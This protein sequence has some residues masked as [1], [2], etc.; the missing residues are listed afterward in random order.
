LDTKPTYVQA[1]DIRWLVAEGFAAVL[2]SLDWQGTRDLKSFPE[3]WLVK[4]NT[5]RTV[6]HLPDPAVPDGPGYFVKRYKFRSFK[7]KLKHLVVPTKAM[8]EWRICGDLRASGIPT[9][10]VLAA[11]EGRKRALLREAFLISQEIPHTVELKKF[12]LGR[13][14]HERE[15]N[16]KEQLVEE[17]ACLTGRLVRLGYYH[18][19]FHAGNILIQPDSPRGYRL[20]VL[21]L[22]SVRKRK[23]RPRHVLR[24]LSMLAN[25]TDLPGVT[26]ADRLRFLVLF[27]RTWKG[28]GRVARGEVLWWA[29]QVESKRKVLHTRHM[30][31]RTRRCLVQSTLF[32]R[33]NYGAYYVHRRRDFPVES[34]CKAAELH[35]QTL[36]GRD[37][38][39]CL[40]KEGDRTAVTLC[41]CDSV[42]PFEVNRPAEPHQL[43]EGVVCVKSFSHRSLGDRLKDVF[44]FR[45]R[46]RQAWIGLSGFAA[47]G[48]PAAKPLALLERRNRLGAGPDFL[49][50]EALS[51]TCTLHQFAE[52]PLR[53]DERRALTE[54]LARLLN[55]LF[56]KAV[57][58]PDLKPTNVL[59]QDVGGEVKLWLVDMARVRFQSHGAK[60]RWIRYLSQLNAGLPLRITMLD[61]MRFLRMCS[62]GEWD[63]QERLRIAKAVYEKSLRRRPLWLGQGVATVA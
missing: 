38:G 57:Y 12:V 15:G 51:D 6:A 10:E 11:G 39:C 33:H 24:M 56:D 46:A 50:M 23:L 44:R 62:G 48:L 26:P 14:W 49:I 36:A 63:G 17:L 52:R 54:A 27:L 22:H 21:D 4:D 7:E 19:D 2:A 45:S 53:Q 60:R 61:R 55:E 3:R 18:R 13:G 40:C 58:H 31:S 25:S 9:C 59:V 41:P 35:M 42:P 28:V 37:A 30:R 8:Q 47:R 29:G 20:F 16:Y 1:G 34:A 5:V 32:T 43:R